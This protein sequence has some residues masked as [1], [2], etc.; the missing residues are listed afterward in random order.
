MS[1][2]IHVAVVLRKKQRRVSIADEHDYQRIQRYCRELNRECNMRFRVITPDNRHALHPA[3]RWGGFLF[4][5]T[6]EFARRFIEDLNGYGPVFLWAKGY[7][8]TIDPTWSHALAVVQLFFNSSYLSAAKDCYSDRTHYLPTAFHDPWPWTVADTVGDLRNRL[9]DV[10]R[11][12]IVFSGS[13]RHVR[14]DRYRQR[15]LNLLARRGLK[16]CVAAPHTV[17]N[18]PH[19]DGDVGDCSLDPTITVLGNWGTE[20]IFQSAHCILDL[21]W[22][23]TIFTS[24]PSHHDPNGSVFA[25]GWNIF[26]AGAYGA[27]LLT[28]DCPANRALGVDENHCRFYQADISDLH[29]LADE[30]TERAAECRQSG[31]DEGKWALRRLFHEKHTYRDR[32]RHIYREIDRHYRSSSHRS[33][34]AKKVGFGRHGWVA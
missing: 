29:A 16:I 22:L 30:I 7:D 27:A 12:D 17:W 23:D 5:G 26:R 10:S 6:D 4:I 3:E 32:W 34:Q 24:H 18:R 2:G 19:Q 13:D 1:S 28:Y 33:H 14:P 8:L 15:L 11:F 21:P 31:Y 20:R 9:F 25:L